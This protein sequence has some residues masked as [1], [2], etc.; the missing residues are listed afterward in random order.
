[1]LVDNSDYFR[2]CKL[3]NARVS[4]DY[5]IHVCALRRVERCRRSW[6]QL[7]QHVQR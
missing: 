4:Y 7:E 5:C 3:K 1:M 2:F 6:M